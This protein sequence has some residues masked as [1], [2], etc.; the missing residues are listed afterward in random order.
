MVCKVEPSPLPRMISLPASA[1]GLGRVI[2]AASVRPRQGPLAACWPGSLGNSPSPPTLPGRT[3][4]STS[5]WNLILPPNKLLCLEDPLP[6]PI[7]GVME[8]PAADGCS[9]QKPDVKNHS[10]IPPGS[11]GARAESGDYAHRLLPWGQGSPSSGLQ[12]TPVQSDT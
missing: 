9:R 12:A 10:V 6:L 8:S 5:A 1:Q 4:A 11:E 2:T 3:S 7:F